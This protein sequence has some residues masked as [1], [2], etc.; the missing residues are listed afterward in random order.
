MTESTDQIERRRYFVKL[1]NRGPIEWN[2]WRE[3]NKYEIPALPSVHLV[4]R[5]LARI[6]FRQMSL[7]SCVFEHTCFAEA[8]LQKAFLRGAYL[9][10]ADFRGADLGWADLGDA[11][12][13]GADL[14][15]AILY[16][17][18][19]SYAD[20]D[21]ANLEGANLQEAQLQVTSLA[22][23]NLNGVNLTGAS[24]LKT[25]LSHASLRGAWLHGALCVWTK[26]D[27]ADLTG[28]HVFG[29]SAW[30][31][32]LIDT[33][34]TD[35][36][37]T[38]NDD[39]IASVTVDSLPVAQFMYLL[40]HNAAIRDVIDTVAKKAVLILG[41]FT[42]ERKVVLEAVRSAL[43]AKGYSPIL[44]DFEKPASRNLTETIRILAGLAR[45]V[46]ADVTDAR[47]IPQELMAIVPN[48]P[49]V[50]VQPLLLSSQQEYGM[51][52]HFR[53]YP[54]VLPETIYDGPEQLIDALDQSVIRP[55]ELKALQVQNRQQG[56]SRPG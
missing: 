30:D 1:L 33:R 26:F 36:V 47:S 4:G 14:R 34:Q 25:D 54:W 3:A 49:S 16:R 31:V 29:L 5:N 50:P 40:L 11:K 51:F 42:P 38:P 52:E 37:I 13:H 24:L 2:A 7:G 55:A 21:G 8:C 43:R 12:L 48:M 35:L 22:A 23:A 41:R 27:H 28:C 9:A 15:N 20:L 56:G 18:D 19:L 44:F 32:S 53:Q 6:N 46:I 45:F 39:K 10:D 17:A